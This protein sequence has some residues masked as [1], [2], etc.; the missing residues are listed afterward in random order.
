ML[1]CSDT[2]A[3]QHLHQV[4]STSLKGIAAELQKCKLPGQVVD[5]ADLL[6]KVCLIAKHMPCKNKLVV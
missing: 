5:S 6:F 2:I 1:F 3:S 4:L